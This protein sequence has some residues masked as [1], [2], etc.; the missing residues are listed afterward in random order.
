MA[1]IGATMLLLTELDNRGRQ[2]CRTASAN[3]APEL[4][5]APGRRLDTKEG[6]WPME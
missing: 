6:P 5:S 1:S 3:K 2:W 4:R